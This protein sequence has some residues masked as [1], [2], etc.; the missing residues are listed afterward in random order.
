MNFKSNIDAVICAVPVF[1]L[2]AVTFPIESTVA[3][4]VVSL[5]QSNIGHV[6]KVP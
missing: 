3:T 2:E 5:V 4:E 1:V 6:V